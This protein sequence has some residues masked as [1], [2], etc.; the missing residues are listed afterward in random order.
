MQNSQVFPLVQKFPVNF[1]KFYRKSFRGKHLKWLLLAFAPI[2]I[3]YS[4][5]VYNKS[6]GEA[7]I[8]L[9]SY[10]ARAKDFIFTCIFLSRLLSMHFCLQ[11]FFQKI[12]F[13]LLFVYCLDNG[14][15]FFWNIGLQIA[16]NTLFL[17]FSWNLRILWGVMKRNLLERYIE[18][19]FMCIFKDLNQRVRRIGE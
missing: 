2:E 9:V 16:K 10:Y 12:K 1:A 8:S 18:L 13:L 15:K 19:S 11:P 5:A 17:H 7:W 4:N 6:A 3:S 14:G